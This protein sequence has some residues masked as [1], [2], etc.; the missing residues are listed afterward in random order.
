MSA[1]FHLPNPLLSLAALADDTNC[2]LGTGVLLMNAWSPERLAYE[3]TVV[4]GI[5]GGRLTI[6]IAPGA[7]TLRPRMVGEPALKAAQI[8][9][10][11][12]SLRKLWAESVVPPPLRSGGPQLVLGGRTARAA[13]RAALM[14]DG[15]YASTTHGFDSIR[16]LALTYNAERGS[17]KPPG[18]IVVNRLCVVSSTDEAAREMGRSIMQPV[19]ER[20]SRKGSLHLGADS[21]LLSAEQVFD[22]LC[23]AGSPQT[24][25]ERIRAYA[26]IGVTDLALRIAPVQ[27]PLAVVR[28]IVT[29][30]GDDVLPA[31]A[32]LPD[33]SLPLEEPV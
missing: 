11:L 2:E 22:Q 15:Y 19:I 13:R 12:D 29:T 26:D 7:A 8:E 27:A 17:S 33:P 31:V 24:V 16:S 6:G 21:A 28:H 23:L 30:L 18:R 25:V 1:S 9:H 20:Y 32:E 5:S 4:D 10:F 14:A 3:A